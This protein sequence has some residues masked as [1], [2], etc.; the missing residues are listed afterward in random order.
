V[1][2]VVLILYAPNAVNLLAILE[3]FPKADGQLDVSLTALV[4]VLFVE[5]VGKD[6][7]QSVKNVD[8][9]TMRIIKKLGNFTF[10]LYSL[11]ITRFGINID[12]KLL[13]IHLIWYNL[14]IDWSEK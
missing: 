10:Y 8:N 9:R 6:I 12:Y 1:E 13:E 11:R 2:Q 5:S 3:I 14:I 4:V 7:I